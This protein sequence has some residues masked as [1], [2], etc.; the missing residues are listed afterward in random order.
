MIDADTGAKVHRQE[1]YRLN[2]SKGGT[3]AIT[4]TPDGKLLASGGRDGT[5]RLWDVTTGAERRRFD[6]HLG[7]V[8]NL[9]V[10]PDGKRLITSGSDGLAFVWDLTVAGQA[11]PLMIVPTKSEN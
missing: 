7:E 8:Y 4:F 5:V 1:V 10:S 9:A 6:G 2:G 11:A 3:Q